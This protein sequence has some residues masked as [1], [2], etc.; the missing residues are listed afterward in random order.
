MS[1][2]I[3]GV[4]V[5]FGN[6]K[7]T[8]TVFSS[9]VVKHSTKPPITNM[10]VETNSGFY[11]VGNPKITIQESKLTNEDMLILTEAAIAEELKLQGI[12]SADIHLGVGVPLTRMGVEKA[13]MIDY[14]TRNRKLV[15]KY[16]DVTYSVNLLSV[17]VFPQGY[18]GVV[19]Y[20]S[21]FSRLA[22][23]IDIGSWTIDIMPIRERKPDSA[24][25]KSLSLGT[26]TCMHKINE[27]LREQFNGEADEI[28]IKDV[29]ITGSSVDLPPKYLTVIQN[30]LRTYVEEIMGQLR[31]L[32]FNLDTTQLVFIGGG[33]SII[34]HFLDAQ[35]YPKATIIEDVFINAKGYEDLIRY[36]IRN[37]GLR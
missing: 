33:A 27:H 29:M 14:Y 23:V 21:K 19:N 25:C 6:T 32:Q 17:N 13:P 16:E 2:L 28:L 35:K 34:K 1:E 4:D 31:A 7:T 37:G 12:T 11:T 10:V 24:N 18:A 5:G 26:I 22:V 36:Q 20:I 15:F 8:H 9:G 3:I 30:D